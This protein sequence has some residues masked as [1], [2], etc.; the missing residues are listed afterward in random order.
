MKGD[1][2]KI[3][4]DPKNHFSAVLMQ[5]GRVQ[6]DA[7]WNEQS[8]ITVYRIERET[9]DIIGDCGSSFENAGFRI[10]KALS[11]LT[12]DEVAL[13][14]ENPAA[15]TLGA[16]DFLISP[17]RYYV[18]GILTQNDHTYRY[19]AQPHLPNPEMITA[20]GYYLAYL[21]VWSR[22]ITKLEEPS[23]RE[24]AL[25]GPD[26][27]TRLQTIWQV[28]Q[29]RVGDLADNLKDCS[30][31]GTAWI[32]PEDPASSG[33]ARG[34]LRA[35]V[36]PIVTTS[37]LCIIPPNAGYQRLENQLY[38]VEI[39]AGSGDPGGPTFVWSRENANIVVKL[40]D[41]QG[42]KL[43][44]SEPG[45]DD[46]LGFASGQWVE[47]SDED[48]VLNQKPGV[49]VKLTQA[50]GT[51][52]TVDPT[53]WPGAPLTMADFDDKP[54]V[55]RW[56]MP[57]NITGPL[58]VNPA[59][60]TYTNLEGGV[61]VK[62]AGSEFRCGDYWLIPART[63]EGDIVWPQNGSQPKAKLPEGI[64]NHFCPL[65]LLKFDSST[66]AP[67]IEVVHDCRNLF[68]P[69]T[70]QLD[71]FHIGG[72]GQEG[73]PPTAGQKLPQPLEVGLTN[74]QNP[75]SGAKVRFEI[76]AVGGGSVG[77][78]LHPPV[79]PA[80]TS[81]IV[82]TNADGIA[83]C[84]WE[85]NTGVANASQRV[86][87]TL[88]T[89]AEVPVDD[90]PALAFNANLSLASQVAYGE[91]GDCLNPSAPSSV[92]QA[93][94]DL[95]ENFGMYYVSGDG[96][97]IMPTGSLTKL[98]ALLEVFVANGQW[99]VM[100]NRAK[101]RFAI[102]SGLG[103]LRLPGGPSGSSTLTVDLGAVTTDGLAQCEWHVD[104]TTASQKATATLVDTGGT[105]IQGVPVITFDAFLSR[106]DN[107]AYDPT[108]CPGL[109]GSTTVQDAIDKL[110]GL[111]GAA[112]PGIHIEEVTLRSS[113]SALVH[114]SSIQISE[115]QDGIDFSLDAPIDPN[116]VKGLH[117]SPA[118][119]LTVEIPS[120]AWNISQPLFGYH[121]VVLAANVEATSG[122]QVVRWI[123]DTNVITWLKN[124]LEPLFDDGSVNK[125][126]TRVTL[127]G[128]FIWTS[129]TERE[130]LNGDALGVP[131]GL[132]L[133]SGDPVQGG[134]FEMWF[135]LAPLQNFGVFDPGFFFIPVV[136]GK[137]IDFGLL[138]ALDKFI[139]RPE[140]DLG[141]VGDPER[142]F[143]PTV[144]AETFSEAGIDSISIG[145]VSPRKT[146][147]KI[148]KVLKQTLEE[149]GISAEVK[150]F[151]SAELNSAMSAG[152]LDLVIGNNTSFETLA[153]HHTDYFDGSFVR[154]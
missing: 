67:S 3:T 127:K 49:L 73:M 152:Q 94:D 61:Q 4:F 19:A 9:V 36:D 80:G 23:I 72:T 41:I 92:K 30:G 70:E 130:Y 116:T 38:R 131:S 17:G 139:N 151:T 2:T 112:N 133:P 132:T 58:P 84:E 134:D 22:H 148:A 16:G 69:L 103:E 32:P 29:M 129:D 71:F 115:L 64:E 48:K 147:A 76:V 122:N 96:Q 137:L 87:A 126:L 14:L 85:L 125:V 54:T 33:A 86:E 97:L 11:D 145:L 66:P 10:V 83:S 105:P 5:Q 62:F 59:S 108:N 46:V 34:K 150:R 138:S 1:F 15:L 18:D 99:P 142:P 120:K 88:L 104:D 121:P 50:E 149:H 98:S 101:V 21:Q 55:R 119:F 135:W 143:D 37:E 100:D 53:T 6:L 40:E 24:S 114:N 43:I 13:L 95:C 28:K 47:L 117:T 77:G 51:E 12:A 81:V 136:T 7:D 82:S 111:E 35:Q 52:L 60:P 74:G 31:W 79:G 63:L 44:V 140:L 27:A 146:D 75:V 153:D 113:S 141:G 68:S 90:L 124:N 102:V 89:P 144:A 93:L 154:I 57:N 128:N 118:C 78:N 20:D 65:A 25:N 26:T 56:D 109:S 107:V 39:F 45:K 8:E 106:A 42:D 123:P 91:S 110:C